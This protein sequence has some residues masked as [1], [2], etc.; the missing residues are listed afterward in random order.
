MNPI[1]TSEKD[2]LP[3]IATDL[4]CKQVIQDKQAEIMASHSSTAPVSHESHKVG[5]SRIDEDDLDMEDDPEYMKYKE[6]RIAELKAARQE[7]V[8]NKAK[9][10]GE[11]REIDETEFLSTVTKNKRGVCH[12]YHREFERCKIVDEHLKR[13]CPEHIE[14]LFIKINA[15]KAP[16]F[17]TKLKVQ[18]LPTL[19]FFIDGIAVDRVVGF[20]ELGGKDD[21]PTLLLTRRLVRSKVIQAKRKEENPGFHIAKGG[22]DDSDDSGDD[23]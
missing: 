10:H 4:V 22:K 16:F 6:K 2:L 5:P 11:Y 9:G 18:V 21:F 12:F 14:A 13:I 15:E 19:I 17:I 23:E 3:S 7:I 8:I 1:G 20:E